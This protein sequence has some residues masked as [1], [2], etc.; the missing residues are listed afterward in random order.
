MFSIILNVIGTL[1]H[2]YVAGRLYKIRP[3]RDRIA[4]PAWWLGAGFIWLLYIAGIQIG[5]EA[6]DWRWWPGQFAMT[7]IGIQFVMALCL[8][9]ADLVTGFGLWW[10][11]LAPRLI[12]VAAVAGVDRKSVV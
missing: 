8:L 3:I 9:V 6:L 11:N 4:A 7:W 5:D 10:R 1:L 12:A 2:F